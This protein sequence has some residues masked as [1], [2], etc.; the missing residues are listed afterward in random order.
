MKPSIIPRMLLCCVLLL[1]ALVIRAD[2][3]GKLQ[4]MYTA[5]LD[6]SALFPKTLAS[7]VRFDPST[8]SELQRLYDQWYQMHGRYQSE[9]QQLLSARLIAQMGEQQAQDFIAR[10]KNGVQAELVPLYFPQNHTWRD[11]WFCTKLLPKDLTGQGLMLDFA[12]Y[13]ED[14]RQSALPAK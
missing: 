12:K 5:Y 11:N 4:F 10:I 14:L 8:G 9:L 1:A 2:N 13:A 6:V 7:C 3:T